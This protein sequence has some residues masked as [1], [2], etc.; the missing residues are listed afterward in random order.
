MSTRESILQS[1]STGN[2]PD[3]VLGVQNGEKEDTFLV[4]KELTLEKGHHGNTQ[5]L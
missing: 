4:L 5:S 3:T 2:V 1:M